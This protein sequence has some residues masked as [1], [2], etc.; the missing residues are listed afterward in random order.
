MAEVALYPRKM[1]TR[2]ASVFNRFSTDVWLRKLVHPYSSHD[3]GVDFVPVLEEHGLQGQ[4]VDAGCQLIPTS[5]LRL[6]GPGVFLEKC[7]PHRSQLRGSPGWSTPK[8]PQQS[9]LPPQCQRGGPPID[10]GL[11]EFPGSIS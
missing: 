8:W 1:A 7:C 5:C 3:A 9:P 11:F 10:I 6:L 4:S 2:L